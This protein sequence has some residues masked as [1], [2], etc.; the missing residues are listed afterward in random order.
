MHTD[1]QTITG[2]DGAAQVTPNIAL[3]LALH[4]KQVE[5][6]QRAVI[7]TDYRA[8]ID[9][10]KN[11]QPRGEVDFGVNWTDGAAFP[12]WRV[13]WIIATGE[14]YAVEQTS[15]SRDRFILFGIFETR[16]EVEDVLAGWA[17]SNMTLDWIRERAGVL[18]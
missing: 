7:F 11:L 15:P 18:Q 17:D 14:L 9:E 6:E 8:W 16:A 2:T 10:R 1:S 5:E 13:S 12:R 3:L 4:G